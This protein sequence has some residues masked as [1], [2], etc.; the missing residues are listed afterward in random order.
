MKSTLLF[1]ALLAAS[2][3]AFADDAQRT[4]DSRAL[5]KEFGGSLKA[6]LMA[7][8]QAGGPVAAIGVC[9]EKAPGIAQTLAT[10]QGWKI[11]RT[12]L[13]VRNPANAPTDWQ[14]EVLNRFETAKAQGADVNT[15][16]YAETV[17]T[18]SGSEFRYM[19]AIP[20]GQVCLACHGPALAPEVGAKIKALYPDDQAT[21]FHA[22]DIRGAFVIVQPVQN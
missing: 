11:G 5:V 9:N 4:A 19:N 1:A 3:P 7:A 8:M 22:G 10:R 18:E 16:E 21:G 20:T 12:A 13:K 6:E 14:R 15:L 2:A 17:A